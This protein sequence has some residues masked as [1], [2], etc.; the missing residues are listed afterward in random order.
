MQKLELA[1]GTVASFF[2][3]YGKTILKEKKRSKCGMQ[4]GIILYFLPDIA[5]VLQ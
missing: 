2:F 3:I 4:R 1:K 5:G